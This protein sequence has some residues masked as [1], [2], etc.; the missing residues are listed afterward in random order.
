[1]TTDAIRTLRRQRRR[2]VYRGIW[3]TFL[4]TLSLSLVVA[5]VGHIIWFRFGWT[6]LS[7]RCFDDSEWGGWRE[8]S[9]EL[10]PQAA[11]SFEAILK[12]MYGDAAVRRSNTGGVLVRP[13]VTHFDDNRRLA[14]LTT[15]VTGRYAAAMGTSYLD[16]TGAHDCRMTQHY[17]LASR[18]AKTCEDPWEPHVFGVIG[19]DSWP[20]LT[21]FFLVRQPGPPVLNSLP[22]DVLPHPTDAPGHL[23]DPAVPADIVCEYPIDERVEFGAIYAVG[24]VVWFVM[25]LWPF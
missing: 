13:A 8:L 22:D 14:E 19:Q 1:M 18:Q 21:R 17:L 23:A 2:R 11:T 4:W 10:S 6:E 25:S 5:L 9:G 7:L 16:E 24:S 20:W 15:L 12:T 3:R